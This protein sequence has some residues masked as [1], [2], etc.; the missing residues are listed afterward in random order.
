MG[1]PNW[2]DVEDALARF[3]LLNI[4][5]SPSDND[6]IA[7]AKAAIRQ[8]STSIPGV[9]T[10]RACVIKGVNYYG[11]TPSQCSA[12]GGQCTDQGGNPNPVDVEDALARFY[13]LNIALNIASSPSDNDIANAKTAILQESTSIPG[14]VTC[15]AC[16]IKGVNYY[17]LTPSQCSAMGGQCDK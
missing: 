7:S 15:R 4:A 16:V 3:Y 1:N 2:A 13:L 12:M 14:V 10:C 11:L 6:I 5:S 8:D 17:G 9:A